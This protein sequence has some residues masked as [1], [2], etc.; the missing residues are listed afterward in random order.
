[1]HV[2]DGT[3]P[4]QQAATET[5]TR[6]AAALSSFLLME[7][8]VGAIVEVLLQSGL[9]HAA[10][11]LEQHQKFKVAGRQGGPLGRYRIW[12]DKRTE[13]MIPNGIILRYR[14]RYRCYILYFGT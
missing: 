11:P 7:V 8:G 4:L 1:M 3:R 5:S 9:E 10:V 6:R 14:Y 13:W 12:T 2:E